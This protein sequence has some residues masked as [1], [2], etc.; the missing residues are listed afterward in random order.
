MFTFAIFAGA[1]VMRISGGLLF[2]YIGDKF[3]R[4]NALFLSI[5]LMSIATT[6]VGC[7]P[8]FA[9]VG[10]A[11]PILLFLV[12]LCQGLSVGGQVCFAH[13]LTKK[14]DNQNNIYARKMLVIKKPRFIVQ[15]LV[16]TFVV[17]IENAPPGEEGL[18]GAIGG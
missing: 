15:Q 2:G 9:L 10:F 18:Y 17:A 3:G 13:A 7:L 14:R 1:F 5:L 8:T 12:R 4:K 16:G 11:A 6:L